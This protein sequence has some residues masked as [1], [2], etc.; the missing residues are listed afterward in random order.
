MT[1]EEDI[2]RQINSFK[3]LQVDD[4]ILTFDNISFSPGL[5]VK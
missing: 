2:A 4:D 1:G 5:V 3:G